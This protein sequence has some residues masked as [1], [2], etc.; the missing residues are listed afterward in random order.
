[1][2]THVCMT[3]TCMPSSQ[4]CSCRIDR[5]SWWMQFGAA[6]SVEDSSWGLIFCTTQS[7]DTLHYL[8]DPKENF[9]AGG[10]SASPLFC[11]GGYWSLE[12]WFSCTWG[13]FQLVSPDSWVQCSSHHSGGTGLVLLQLCFCYWLPDFFRHLILCHPPHSSLPWLLCQAFANPW[14]LNNHFL[15]FS[16]G[17]GGGRGEAGCWLD[18]EDLGGQ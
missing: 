15:A 11:P 16:A 7:G 9:I 14:M 12:R 4:L 3:S 17:Q 1:M 6:C 2:P 13:Q 8:R 10:S 18:N 5:G